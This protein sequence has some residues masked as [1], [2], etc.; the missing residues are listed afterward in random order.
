[1]KKIDQRGIHVV[2]A[3]KEDSL[4]VILPRMSG[5]KTYGQ[6]GHNELHPLP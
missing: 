5:S 2:C 6:G 1:M 4:A 3:P